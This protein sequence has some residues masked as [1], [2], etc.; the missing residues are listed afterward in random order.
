MVSERKV[1]LRWLLWRALLGAKGTKEISPGNPKRPPGSFRTGPAQL[2]SPPPRCAQMRLP[3]SSDSFSKLEVTSLVMRKEF[4][5]SSQRRG[6]HTIKTL[7]S[8]DGKLA[9]GHGSLG[10]VGSH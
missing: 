8:A 5:L 2:V 4:P 3:N 9:R 7:T 10:L 6:H 1:P